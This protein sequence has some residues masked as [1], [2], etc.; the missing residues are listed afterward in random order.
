MH[1]KLPMSGRAADGTPAAL[2]RVVRRPQSIDELRDEAQGAHSFETRP[3]LR[4]RL[5]EAEGPRPAPGWAFPDLRPPPATHVPM[6]PP[7]TR[8]RADAALCLFASTDLRPPPL[9]H[10]RNPPIPTCARHPLVQR[11][12]GSSPRADARPTGGNPPRAGTSD[13]TRPPGHQARHLRRTRRRHS[14]GPWPGGHPVRRPFARP[15]RRPG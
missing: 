1:I 10:G 5:H 13:G 6:P 15:G 14:V 3:H 8:P 2:A 11:A 7:D 9:G 4:A 12:V